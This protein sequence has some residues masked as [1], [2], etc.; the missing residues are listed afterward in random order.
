MIEPNVR[1]SIAVLFVDEFPALPGAH[2]PISFTTD[3][4]R[5]LV[6]QMLAA[7][8]DKFVFALRQPEP[9][10]HSCSSCPSECGDRPGHF[11]V[12]ILVKITSILHESPEDVAVQVQS[13][14]RVQLLERTMEHPP[15]FTFK[16]MAD[17]CTGDKWESD[18]EALKTTYK[19]ILAQQPGVP[20]NLLAEMETITDPCAYI[21]SVIHQIDESPLRVYEYLKEENLAA[22]LVLLADALRAY[23][24]TEAKEA[25]MSSAAGGAN[26]EIRVKLI[27]RIKAK[28][29]PPEAHDECMK[30]VER[31]GHTRP[32]A[33]EYGTI[34]DFLETMVALP[35]S[36]STEDK[37]DLVEA[38]RIL[39]ED[40]F[41]LDDVKKRV[42]EFL[43]VVKLAKSNRGPIL[44][45]VGPPGTG[46]TSIVKSIARAMGRKYVRI[47]LGG[48]HDES[49]IRG[50]RR[51][52]VG[53][54]PGRF[55]KA[56]KEAGVNNPVICLDEIDKIGG[57][58]NSGD[59]SAALLE[60]LDP[61]QN[62][63]FHDNYLG[64]KYDLSKVMFVATG[65]DPE[66]ISAPVFD[67]MEVVDIEGYTQDDK[68]EI[69]KG[70]LIP[71]N[72]EGHGLST[73]TFKIERKALL[74]IID[75]YTYEAG[76]RRLEQRIQSLMRRAAYDVAKGATKV[77]ITPKRVRKEFGEPGYKETLLPE[78]T[79]GAVAGLCVTSY[80]GALLFVEAKSMPGKGGF[81]V[82]GRAGETMMESSDIVKSVVRGLCPDWKHEKVDVHIHFPA[83]GTPKDG[84]S[85]GVTMTTALYSVVTKQAIDN[86]VCMTGEV[87]LLGRVLPIGGLGRKL[88]AAFRAGC[89]RAV[90]PFD[91]HKD[92]EEEVAAEV[93]KG[94]SV[95][96]VKNVQ[97]L[98]A[99]VF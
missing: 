98:I 63:Q 49:E 83:G 68:E 8:M 18:F 31:L 67:R 86:K 42:L 71:R 7:G 81:K 28:G 89:T 70:W 95:K 79:I 21:Y 54:M 43:A 99:E 84:P 14:C 30:E 66:N 96:F 57:R 33:S 12:G 88:M 72:L 58:S 51:T 41:G 74:N 44:C 45:L 76:V 16:I 13:L 87:D 15:L 73:T 52:Y 80:G 3:E 25:Q 69:A 19:R 56:M 27:A 29:M 36:E 39:K 97:E 22:T 91:N 40:H 92:Y 17:V 4:P 62:S 1:G 24:P 77:T 94:L 32:D 48:V 5:E 47:S 78:P 60:V 35:W 2:V 61:E 46:K 85:A 37:I 55:M 59:P 90:V 9:D 11:P 6:R 65:N 10:G 34:V 23:D 26:S 53:S 75:D 82:T 20:E 93:K 64:V 50:H 38:E